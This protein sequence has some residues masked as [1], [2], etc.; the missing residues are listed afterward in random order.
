MNVEPAGAEGAGDDERDEARER[1]VAPRRVPQLADFPRSGPNALGSAGQ[2][3]AGWLLDSI[4]INGPLGLMALPY[5][6]IAEDGQLVFDPPYWVTVLPV[7]VFVVYQIAALAWR[8][9]TLGML[10]AGI[11][12]ARYAD[13]K[14]PRLEQAAIRQLLPAV[15]MLVPTVSLGLALLGGVQYLILFS[16]LWD[17]SGLRRAWHDKASGTILVR[18]R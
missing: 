3:V 17:P 5:L 6:S 14:R 18:T 1:D 15:F 8:G 16:F 12:L 7:V 11:R 9:Q 4:L 10:A 2:R 13:G